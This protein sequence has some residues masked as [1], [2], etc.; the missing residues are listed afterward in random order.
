MARSGH[1]TRRVAAVSDVQV[2]AQWA[3]TRVGSVLVLCT[4]GEHEPPETDVDAWLI[5]VTQPDFSKI[6]LHARGGTPDAKQRAR[7]A[8][9]WNKAPP[10]IPPCAVVTDSA[11]VR[12]VL[13]AL[14][15]ISRFPFRAFAANELT[16]ALQYL[17]EADS[18]TKLSEAIETLHD[19]LERPQSAR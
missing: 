8:A 14:S 2:H 15:W 9:Y 4:Q 3:F 12:S 6:L 16:S 19:A 5:R 11:L 1:T 13:V 10:P 18:L 17:E 7:L